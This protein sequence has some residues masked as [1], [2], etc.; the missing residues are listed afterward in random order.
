MAQDISTA[1][2]MGGRSRRMGGLKKALFVR[3]GISVIQRTIDLC[4]QGSIFLVGNEKSAYRNLGIPIFDDK[5]PGKGAPGALVTALL[6]AQ[7]KWV[8]VLACDLPCMDKKT[9]DGLQPIPKT[10]VRLYR[11][12]GRPQYLVSLWRTEIGPELLERVRCANLSFKDLLDGLSVD[13]LPAASPDP[14]YN[15]NDMESAKQMRF[16]PGQMR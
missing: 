4:E 8:R 14:F 15:M 6:S 5:V 7:T 2:L 10:D 1:I 13:W 16:S 9:L 11:A 12:D 3:D